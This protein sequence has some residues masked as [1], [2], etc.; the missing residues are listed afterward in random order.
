MQRAPP[1]RFPDLVAGSFLFLC[2]RGATCS[3]RALALPV[4][5][6]SAFSP[7]RGSLPPRAA[8]RA[9]GL[10]LVR[11]LGGEGEVDPRRFVARS[12][13]G[14]RRGWGSPGRGAGH[15]SFRRS[16]LR[17]S[18]GLAGGRTGGG[19]SLRPPSLA[20][21][22]HREARGEARRPHRPGR[23]APVRL[24]VVSPRRGRGPGGGQPPRPAG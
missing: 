9:A 15:S 2:R 6:N 13:P 4:S 8:R 12:A 7:G 11:G 18:P 14:L 3:V 10:A 17:A 1:P 16:G 22:A 23:H 19:G 20:G 5:E 21:G 24:S